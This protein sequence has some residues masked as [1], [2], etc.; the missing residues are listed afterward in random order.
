[1]RP[2][3]AVAALAL[4]VLLAGC[5]REPAKSK[6][7]VSPSKPKAGETIK[8]T[9][10]PGTE[11][12][13]ANADSLL[14][15]YWVFP[16][17]PSSQA[18]AEEV[19]LT[20]Q[21]KHWVAT[22]TVPE[23]AGCLVFQV[24]LA[25]GVGTIDDNDGQC[26][27]VL[28]YGP[29]G[30][31]VPGGYQALASSYTYG[32]F[33]KR[34]RDPDRAKQLLQKELEL[35]PKNLAAA[36]QLLYLE[37]RDARGD[38][39]KQVALVA[40]A[41][42]LARVVPDSPELLT[43]LARV[44]R[45]LQQ[46]DKANQIV[47]RIR[48]IDP[49]NETVLTLEWQQIRALPTAKEQ[50]ARGLELLKRVKDP[51]LKRNLAGW[52]AQTMLG[53]GQERKVFMFLDTLSVPNPSAMNSV[54]WA[55][56]EQNKMLIPATELAGKAVRIYENTDPEKRRPD[57]LPPSVWRLSE[58]R[59]LGAVL[60]TY[61]FGLY[62]L[63][64]LEEA[65]QAYKKAV[66]LSPSTDI[67]Q[68][69]VQCLEDLHKDS[70]AFNVLKQVV[71]GGNTDPRL[72]EKLRALATKR[73]GNT[74]FV[75]SLVES[76]RRKSAES[77][78]AEIE[79]KVAEGIKHAY[80]APGFKLPSLEGDSVALDQFRGKWVVLDFW[81]TWC[82]P[83]KSSFPYLEKFWQNH[84]DKGDVTVLAINCW[85]RKRGEERV[86]LVRD[87]MKENGYTFPVLLDMKDQV[88]KAYRVE[89]IPT[90]FFVGPDGKV[91][92]KEVGFGG[93]TMLDDMETALE[94]LKKQVGS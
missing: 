40:K 3:L 54:A 89:G 4:A 10:T 44:Y 45:V 85:Q 56:I 57:Y 27:D 12:V 83:C 71:E 36:L 92:L 43:S 82:G 59:S 81:A 72:V 39:T 67:V 76:V 80:E 2:R 63:G 79:K 84:K 18:R 19:K 41:D 1:M 13:L 86:K 17:S 20:R 53:A 35:H 55:L 38:S 24:S 32:G 65:E 51:S 30:K 15:Q 22:L 93:A 37:A 73:M 47:E 91:Y 21:G 70:L 94:L 69:Y 58:K 42:S 52:I 9:Y 50:V 68:R 33:L 25:R 88:V 23:G 66:E 6:L 5:S 77:K 14:L 26:W 46:Q 11:S 61:A 29:D 75:D 28:V 48:Q 16:T 62:K 87:F 34:K 8:V 90:K 7:T 60:D 64:K 49:N 31:V 74:A 78:R